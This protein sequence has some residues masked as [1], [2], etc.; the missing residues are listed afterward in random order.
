[1]GLKGCDCEE[2]SAQES[3]DAVID[4]TSVQIDFLN[5]EGMN[6]HH[7][8][9]FYYV[10]KHGGL[11]AAARGIPYGIQQPAISS[12]VLQLEQSLGRKLFE[13]KPF[14]LTVEGQALFEFI[15]PFFAELEHV[16]RQIRGKAERVLRIGAPEAI[17]LE[18]LPRVLKALGAKIAGFRFTLVSAGLEE[19]EAGLEAGEFDLGIAPLGSKNGSGLKRKV[20][21]ELRMGLLVRKASLFRHASEILEADLLKFSLISAGGELQRLFEAELKRRQLDW[22]PSLKLDSQTL[23]AR[24]VAEG[25]GVGLVLVEPGGKVPSGTRILVL[26]KFPMVSFGVLWRGDLSVL[27]EAFVAEAATTVRLLQG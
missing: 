11:S 18:Y 20:L 17:H 8:E 12:Q 19:I 13:R 22:L 25:F 27:Q 21:V 26:D 9:L 10:A 2:K 24:Y 7:L 14:K 23:V 1:M 3:L 4:K 6:V 16:S 5:S 15:T